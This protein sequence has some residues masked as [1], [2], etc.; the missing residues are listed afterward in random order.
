MTRPLLLLSLLASTACIVVIERAEDPL[1]GD[2]DDPACDVDGDG[3]LSAACGG[4]DC[5]DDDAAVNPAAPELLGDGLDADCD[6][7]PNARIDRFE[8]PARTAPLSWRW[9]DDLRALGGLVVLPTGELVAQDL[10]LDPGF[11]GAVV[12]KKR[13]DYGD[14]GDAS[15]GVRLDGPVDLFVRDGAA[16]AWAP[17]QDVGSRLWSTPFATPLRFDAAHGPTGTWIAGC[18]GATVRAVHIDLIEGA[19]TA[20]HTL[21][22]AATACA[23]LGPT[24]DGRPALITGGVDAALE[25]WVL[26]PNTGFSDRLRLAERVTPAGLRTAS[27]APDAAL[28]FLDDGRLYV[29]DSGGNGTIVGENATDRF[30]VAVDGEGDVL[31][32][33]LDADDALFTAVGRLP[34]APTV[35]AHGPFPGA[36]AVSA[37]LTADEVAV[38]VQQDTDLVLVRAQR[39]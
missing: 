4:D 26:D 38:G 12:L 25:R 17:D 19:T 33:W 16:E 29:F 10:F 34:N 18:D 36:T 39:R 24:A 31:I 2:P 7:D 14:A 1:V 22:R 28:A 15:L 13:S 6:G 20:D 35:Y 21:E 27:R 3:F 9:R 30:D 23:V 37:G 11:G 32:A 5:D 8:A